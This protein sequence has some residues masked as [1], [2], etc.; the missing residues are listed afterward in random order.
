MNPVNQPIAGAGARE[1]RIQCEV[2]LS[3]MQLESKVVDGYWLE[4]IMFCLKTGDIGKLLP[5]L[6]MVNRV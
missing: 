3:P 4:T 5:T 2:D 6:Y 1:C